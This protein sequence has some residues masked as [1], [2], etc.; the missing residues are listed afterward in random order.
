MKIVIPYSQGRIS[1]V[2]DVAVHFYLIEVKDGKEYS[3]QEFDFTVNGI[4]AKTQILSELNVDVLI[5]G[6]ISE[7]QENVLRNAGIRLLAFIC[8][9]VEEVLKAFIQNNLTNGAFQMP[10]CCGRR[11][12]GYRGRRHNLN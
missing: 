4:F 2:F 5:C 12:H 11:R 10:G 1:P 7:I 9:G 8:G 6:A 3:R